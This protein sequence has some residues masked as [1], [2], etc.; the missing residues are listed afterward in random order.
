[1]LQLKGAIAT[2][3]FNTS[4]HTLMSFVDPMVGTFKA[5]FKGDKQLVIWR[6][7]NAGFVSSPVEHASRRCLTGTDWYLREP[8]IHEDVRLRAP[9]RLLDR[10]ER[11][12]ADP[13]W[14][15]Q[16]LCESKW[17]TVWSGPYKSLGGVY[18]MVVDRVSMEQAK[19][20]RAAKLAVEIPER[21][22][23]KATADVKAT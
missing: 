22:F 5:A 1:M 19:G 20:E 18:E 23:W 10:L 8:H 9:C 21:K 7:G 17:P 15:R 6:K 14:C 16:C 3:L 13:R 12:V 2:T 4:P 11:L